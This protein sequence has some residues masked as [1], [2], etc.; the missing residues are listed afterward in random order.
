M[1]PSAAKSAPRPIPAHVPPEL[2]VDFD[3]YDPAAGQG[4]IDY[5]DAWVRFQQTTE[6]PLVWTPRY[7]GHW[8][9]LHGDD[10]FDIHADHERFSSG[11][12]TVPPTREVPPL[13]ALVLDPPQH[14]PYRAFLTEGLSPKVVRAMEPAIRTLIAGLVAEIAPRGGC[15][16][17]A[18]FADVVPM[19]VFLRLVDVPVAD[20]EKLAGWA[21]VN[22]RVSDP[23]QRDAAA[24]SL[25]DYLRPVLAARRANPGEDMLSRIVTAEV[26]GARLS[27]EAALGACTHLM[28]AGLDTVASLLG[29]VMLFL[30]RNPDHRRALVADP[31]AIPGAVKELIRRFPLVTMARQLRA[32]TVLHGIELR[33]GD[34]I[35]VPSMLYNLDAREYADPLAVDW[36]RPVLST[37]TF[38]N[39]VHRC[40]G[41]T[42]GQRELQITLEEWLARIPDFEVD[43][44]RPV[45]VQG[46][47]VATVTALH[48]RWDV[49]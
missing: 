24:R 2:V 1:S 5:H 35:A 7:G 17:V 46:G 10:V 11:R 34:M 43:T 47:I 15:D 9:A 14:G 27:D 6:H 16:F 38:G 13:G 32:D 3:V 40:P 20:R 36:Q 23:A 30:A 37:C 19:T 41:A 18:D 33:E 8:I 31:S 21:A 48:L 25:R 12:N 45:A 4:G 44:T 42:L 29:F 22:T 26:D 28:I 49:P 39:G